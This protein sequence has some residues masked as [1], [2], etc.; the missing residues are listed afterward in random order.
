MAMK[1]ILLCL[2][3]SAFAGVVAPLLDVVSGLRT[4]D[5]DRSEARLFAS[6]RYGNW[7]AQKSLPL[8]AQCQT[9]PSTNRLYHNVG[10]LYIPCGA[11]TAEKKAMCTL[12]S[13]SNCQDVMVAFDHSHYRLLDRGHD[14]TV[15][16]SLVGKLIESVKC[17]MV[18]IS[19]E[20]SN[21]NGHVSTSHMSQCVGDKCNSDRE[22]H[23]NAGGKIFCSERMNMTCQRGRYLEMDSECTENHQC[24]EG[25]CVEANGRNLCLH[26]ETSCPYP[27]VCIDRDERDSSVSCCNFGDLGNSVD[28]AI[29]SCMST[30]AEC[31]GHSTCCSGEC[32]LDEMLVLGQCM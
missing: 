29:N 15:L 20:V 30:G 10:S 24:I 11:D 5:W 18:D 26:L 17:E 16:T 19:M 13:D 25:S 8:D 12:Y 21:S 4:V 32:L 22:C 2:P 31:Y 3:L 9:I 28:L 7:G 27:R 23:S 14:E 6:K 1:I